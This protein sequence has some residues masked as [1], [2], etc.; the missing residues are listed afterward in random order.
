MKTNQITE[1]DVLSVAKG[2]DIELLNEQVEKVLNLFD[3]ESED[4]PSANWY[5]VVEK[6]IYD[7]IDEVID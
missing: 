3:G 7:I 5:L 4:D 1:T 6:I 2:L